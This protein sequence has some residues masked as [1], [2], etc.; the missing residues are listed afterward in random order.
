MGHAEKKTRLI[1][2]LA[3]IIKLKSRKMWWYCGV[4]N[5]D[6]KLSL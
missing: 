4:K 2:K 3:K 5:Q 1:K 6:K